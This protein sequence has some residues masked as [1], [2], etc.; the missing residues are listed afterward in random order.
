MSYEETSFSQRVQL[1]DQ[2][3]HVQKERT[4]KKRSYV[5]FHKK[6]LDRRNVKCFM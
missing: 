6:C 4:H 2:G 1:K 3:H 5:H